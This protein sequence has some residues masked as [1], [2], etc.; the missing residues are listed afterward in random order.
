MKIGV[1]PAVNGQFQVVFHSNDDTVIIAV[2]TKLFS[3]SQY[4]YNY[5]K[6]LSDEIRV[7]LCDACCSYNQ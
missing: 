4:A 6:E 7:P 5:A 2:C 1:N 3:T